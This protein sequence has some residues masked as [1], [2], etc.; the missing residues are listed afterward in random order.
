MY[1]TLL[2]NYY[3]VGRLLFGLALLLPLQMGGL[4][5]AI[6][7]LLWVVIIYVFIAF[8]RLVVSAQKINYFDF[9]FDI[10]FVTAVVYLTFWLSSFLT[11]IYLFPIFF[12]SLVIATRRSF[13]FPSVAILL[14]AMVFFLHGGRT[15]HDLFLDPVLHGFAFFVITLAGHGL[16]E[17][18]ERQEE[19]IRRLE[20][21]RARMQGYERLF[22]VSADLA[23]ELRNP[24]A[25]ISASVQFLREGNSDP[26]L[27]EMLRSE[28]ERLTHLVEGFLLYS[29]PSEAPTEQLSIRQV[30]GSLRL[31]CTDKQYAL[32]IGQDA[33]V[34]AN[35]T[36]L[37]VVFMNVIKNALEAAQT[38]VEVAVSVRMLPGATGDKGKRVLIE[39]EDDGPGIPV[40]DRDRIFEPFVTTKQKGTGLGLAIAYR[41]VTGYQGLIMFDESARLGGARCSVILPVEE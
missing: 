32:H 37:E 26:E 4:L 30:I 1:I 40:H 6:P 7:Q 2:F 19:Y 39:V 29:R 9:F 31:S 25:S 35:R 12:S 41:I 34:C 10:V 28:T 33:L 14:Y 3:M 20:E 23:H 24:L 36:F 16:K 27:V 17:R 21:E 22:R 11:L 15:D 38:R 13:L 5:A 8:V 18:I